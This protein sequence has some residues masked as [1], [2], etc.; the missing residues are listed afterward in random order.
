MALMLS[1][2]GIV[3][4]FILLV[5]LAALAGLGTAAFH[6]QATSMVNVFS[7]KYKAVFLSAFIAFG[8]FGFAL[9]P[10][11]LVPLFQFFGLRATLFTIIPGCVAALLLL[12]YAPKIK[13]PT[14]G[15]SSLKSVYATLK[16]ASSALIA[17]VVVIAIRQLAYTGMLTILPLYFASK[18]LSN[19]A[20]S[21]LV[22]IMLFAGAIGGILGGFISD[23][24]GR[25]PLIAG[26]LIIST[27]FFF[28]FLCTSGVISLIFLALAG[29]AL[30]ASFSVTV[31]AAQEAI[32][33]NKPLASGITIGFA[34]GLGGLAVIF[35]GRLGDRFGLPFAVTV[36]FILPIV[37]GLT[38]LL[39]K[40]RDVH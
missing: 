31:V 40:K 35:I 10:L 20:A 3:Q 1:L 25:K 38:A 2:T 34:G 5:L 13:S 22:T 23:R 37:A 21:H 26:S 18:N 32:P 39:M 16:S 12:I 4:S 29:A 17:L 6:P 14:Q 30:M 8:N 7:G 11:V 28:I 9:G 15:T 33:D 19:I 27:P 24:Y 36:L